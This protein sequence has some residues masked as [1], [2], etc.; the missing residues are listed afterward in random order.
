MNPPIGRVE[1]DRAFISYAG[2]GRAWAKWISVELAALDIDVTMDIQAWRSGQNLQE[3]IN[4]ALGNCTLFVAVINSEYFTPPHWSEDEWRAAYSRVREKRLALTALTVSRDVKMPPLYVDVLTRDLAG[5]TEAAARNQLRIEV[6]RALRREL[7]TFPAPDEPQLYP[8]A[9]LVGRPRFRADPQVERIIDESTREAKD[10]IHAQGGPPDPLL[11]ESWRQTAL[12]LSKAYAWEPP[13]S[14]LDTA[15]EASREIRASIAV[16]KRPSHL[17]ELYSIYSLYSGLLSYAALDLGDAQSAYQHAISVQV[18]AKNASN[19][20]MLAWGKGTQAMILRFDGDF[21][22]SIEVVKDALGLDLSGPS[23]ARLHAQN[24]L[25]HSELGDQ[26]ATVDAVKHSA[27]ALAGG[28]GREPEEVGIFLFPQSKYHYYAGTAYL[29]L[30]HGFDRLATSESAKAIELFR[31]GA[32]EDQSYSDELLAH[33][34]L[35]TGRLHLKDLEGVV[36]A[37]SPVVEAP[38]I[39]R[40]SWHYQWLQRL[41]D[42]LATDPKLRSAR[43]TQDI[44]VLFEEYRLT[45]P[46]LGD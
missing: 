34:H 15:L 40:T 22:R 36:E 44:A 25:G 13:Q 4:D 18:A 14:I 28:H 27:E 11:L 43:A 33:V 46:H 31:S 19:S 20:T 45:S 24:S 37:L 6:G 10:F 2:S 5:L 1:N 7:R 26:K 42:H 9:A 35:A 8:G 3:V 17:S 16:T 41:V 12:S 32:L 29:G 21:R 38:P 39:H 23:L 30:G